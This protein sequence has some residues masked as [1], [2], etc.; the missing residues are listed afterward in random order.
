MAQQIEHVL[1]DGGTILRPGKAMASRPF[2]QEAVCRL[3]GGPQLLKNID[4]G[5]KARGWCHTAAYFAD[6]GWRKTKFTTTSP[7]SSDP[8][9]R[10]GQH[11]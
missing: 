9:K 8:R 1:R 7:N 10:L 2:S 4:D 5:L 6:C 11:R 3:T